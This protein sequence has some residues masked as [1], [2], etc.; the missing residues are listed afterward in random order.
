[1][2]PDQRTEQDLGEAVNGF[3]YTS[4]RWRRLRRSVLVAADYR[5]QYW[6]RYGKMVE[7]D[8]VHHIWPVEDYPQYAWCRW[9]LIA[10]SFE[11]H[12]MMHRPGGYGL[13]ELGEALKRRTI[14]PDRR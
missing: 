14:P 5:C 1:M 2:E 3:D 6:K 9:N 10:L 7:A 12:M 13:S 8:R 4:A 11:A